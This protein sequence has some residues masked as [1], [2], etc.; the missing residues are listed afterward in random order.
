MPSSVHAPTF[1]T[2]LFVNVVPVPLAYTPF[3]S[4][5]AWNPKFSGGA[6]LLVSTLSADA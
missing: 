6:L 4:V 3:P 1:I 2:P 5:Y